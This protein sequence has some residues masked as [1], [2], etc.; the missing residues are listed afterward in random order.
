M[1]IKHVSEWLFVAA[2][3]LAAYGG[4]LIDMLTNP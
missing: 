4:T 3:G 1:I 2:L